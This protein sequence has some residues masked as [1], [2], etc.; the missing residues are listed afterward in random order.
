MLLGRERECGAIDELLDGARASRSGALVLRGE[1]GIGKSA[2]LEYA[3]TRADG[4]RVL[5]LRAVKF[6]NGDIGGPI[7]L[8]RAV[9][10]L[11]TCTCPARYSC[12][13]RRPWPSPSQPRG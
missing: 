8:V 1:A 10:E 12:S 13:R 5:W 9:E 4:M 6:E 11:R 7:A 3:A 2:L